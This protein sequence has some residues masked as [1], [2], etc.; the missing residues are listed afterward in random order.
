MG[1]S[2]RREGRTGSSW[3]RLPLTPKIL[4]PIFSL[5]LLAVF[6]LSGFFTYVGFEADRVSRAAD[7]RAVA[8]VVQG[9]L[10]SGRQFD[11]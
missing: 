7:A 4:L 9:A 10:D 8:T 1:E 11:D 2:R 5:T 3:A 6:G